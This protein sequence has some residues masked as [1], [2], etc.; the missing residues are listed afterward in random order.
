MSWSSRARSTALIVVSALSL[1][2]GCRAPEAAEASPDVS[3][4]P[5]ASP[6]SASAGASACTHY[7]RDAQ[8]D[9]S[10]AETPRRE[11][12][13]DRGYF[14]RT[15]RVTAE[16]L[17]AHK[18]LDRWTAVFHYDAAPIQGE[19]H[20]E[21]VVPWEFA[22]LQGRTIRWQNYRKPISCGGGGAHE[23]LAPT[24]EDVLR[25]DQGRLLFLGVL[26]AG[27]SPDGAVLLA[28]EVAP[29]V[30]V[31]WVDTGCPAASKGGVTARPVALE[32][33]AGSGSQPGVRAP[34]GARTPITIQ[35]ARYEI[36]VSSANVGADGDCGTAAFMIYRDDVLRKV[37]P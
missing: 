36:A 16:E 34:V 19:V 12:E 17:R 14:E 22:S 5:V 7:A 27:T 13:Y 30:Q 29:E 8:L 24:A 31:R 26:S 11:D 35:G 9:V 2:P 1:L 37:A 33:S 18:R 32:V 20:L 25:D 21:T 3:P 10:F 28:P 4:P 23:D 6:A 15:G